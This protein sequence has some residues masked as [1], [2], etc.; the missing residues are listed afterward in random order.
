MTLSTEGGAAVLAPPML[1]AEQAQAMEPLLVVE[2]LTRRLGKHAL[3][4]ELSFAV[5][6]GEAFGI[7]GAN[8]NGKTTLLRLLASLDRPDAGRVLVFG[9]DSVRNAPN[10]RR[11]VGYVPEEPYLYHGITAEQYLHFVGR[12]RG[13]GRLVRAATVDTMLQ[14]VGLEPRRHADIEVLSPGERRRLALAAALQHEPE[15]LLL[16]DPLRSLDG[17]A[18][19]E[20]M[21]VL[22]ELR[23]LGTSM[24]IASTRAEDAL[25]LCD[26]IAVLRDGHFVWEGDP[27]A[28]ASLADP[29]RADAQRVRLELLAGREAAVAMLSQ[30]RDVRELEQDE[31]GRTLWFLFSGDQES[32]AA[33]IPQLVRASCAVAHF[34][35]ERR[36]PAAALS[37]LFRS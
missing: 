34:G 20:Q 22:K 21:E 10:V 28:A 36:T 6:P 3:L 11:R 32:L 16:D 9:L 25:E 14:V 8:G 19:A 23:R 1:D 37:S 29:A 13:L 15:I 30:R 7:T 2:R 31:D 18:R 26:R 12:S 33:M 35:V 17:Q 24:V 5:H 27:A 4:D